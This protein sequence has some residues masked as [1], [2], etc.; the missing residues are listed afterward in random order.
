MNRMLAT[1]GVLLVLGG[2]A[3][4]NQITRTVPAGR[5]TEVNT[6]WPVKPSCQG[7][8]GTAT[9]TVKPQH[10]SVSHHTA[11]TTFGA[12]YR[13]RHCYGKPT[14]SFVVTYT[15]ATGFRGVD[16]FILDVQLPELNVH[17][18]DGYAIIV[19]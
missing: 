14:A 7:V 17:R 2:M 12:N 1:T 3:H 5:T 9:L 13:A 4:A 15:P 11:P 10:G 16:H 8:F 18:L 19:Q 6:Y